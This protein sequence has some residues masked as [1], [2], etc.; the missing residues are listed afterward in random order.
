MQ[1][2]DP[3]WR[4]VRS[5]GLA[6]KGLNVWVYHPGDRMFCGVELMAPP[7]GDSGLERMEVLLPRYAY[8][9]HIGSYDRIKDS[10]L[11]VSEQLKQAGIK[12]GLP[13]L[14]IYGHW[15]ED[16]SKL[17]TELLWNLID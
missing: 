15:T 12:T 2:M 3:L 11:R 8:Y 10:G 4:E 16:V 17:E 7:P 14:E 6:N 5:R 9:K 13:Y 1:L